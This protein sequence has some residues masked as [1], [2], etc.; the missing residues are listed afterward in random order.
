MNATAHQ[1]AVN[2]NNWT[3]K[4]VELEV[5]V[6][7]MDTI[8]FE[9]EGYKFS[10]TFEAFE[11]PSDAELLGPGI[12]KLTSPAWPDDVVLASWTMEGHSKFDQRRGIKAQTELDI[13]RNAVCWIANRV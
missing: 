12:W 2:L 9:F 8:G 4:V 7:S 10:V 5:Q 3:G 13:A 6:N 1:I 11:D